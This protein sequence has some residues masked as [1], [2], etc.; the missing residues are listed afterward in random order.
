ML[1]GELPGA[2]PRRREPEVVARWL[3]VRHGPTAL[4]HAGAY[5][6]WSDVPL[7]GSAREGASRLARRLAPVPVALAYTSDLSRARQTLD[8]LLEDRHPRPAARPDRDLREMHFGAWEGLSYAAIAAQP[9]GP[10]VLAGEHAAPGGESLADLA[11]RVERFGVRLRRESPPDSAGAVLVVSHGGPLR[12]L[13]C[14]LLGLPPSRHWC[15][16]IDHTS[17]SEVHWDPQTGPL[18][19]ALNDR[20]HLDPEGHDPEGHD[21]EGHDA[22]GLDPE[23]HGP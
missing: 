1:C 6:G 16:R 19:V 3:L 8:L 13:F 15:F 14:H 18:V 23:G 21:P 9:G 17:L 20:C 10:A 11:T 4:S 2:L 12:V 7:A 22:Q 5:A